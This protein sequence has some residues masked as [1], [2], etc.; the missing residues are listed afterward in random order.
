MITIKR[1]TENEDG[2][3]DIELS[4][5]ESG[6]QFLVEQGLKA[7][8]VEAIMQQKLGGKYNVSD[9]LG[10]VPKKSGKARRRKSVEKAVKIGSRGSAISVA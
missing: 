7:T 10:D 4:C 3:A 6:L 9:I 1:L 5:N 8:L 2:S